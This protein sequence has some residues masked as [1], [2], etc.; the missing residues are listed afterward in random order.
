M[1]MNEPPKFIPNRPEVNSDKVEVITYWNN[2]KQLE[3]NYVGGVEGTFYF[4]NHGETKFWPYKKEDLDNCRDCGAKYTG[5][6][7]W[8]GFLD[9]G[10][11]VIDME[12]GQL[13]CNKCLNK[14]EK[15]EKKV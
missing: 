13:I 3:E 14:K 4:N 10:W 2:K 11:A 5:S 6:G 12:T 1:S 8:M 7:G 15:Y 9:G